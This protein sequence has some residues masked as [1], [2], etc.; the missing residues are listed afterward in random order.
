MESKTK[1]YLGI[2]ELIKMIP[3]WCMEGALVNVDKFSNQ[4]V[5]IGII[6]EYCLI[7]PSEMPEKEYRYMIENNEWLLIYVCTQS[8]ITDYY[9]DEITPL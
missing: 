2:N 5:G 9:L 4:E 1:E 3:S 6:I 8:E 7:D